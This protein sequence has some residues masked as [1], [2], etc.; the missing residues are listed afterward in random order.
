MTMP[1]QNL[2][3]YFGLDYLVLETS[4]K[5]TFTVVDGPLWMPSFLK[6]CL[7]GVVLR[8]RRGSEI[9]NWSHEF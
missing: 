4:M 3:R 9:D 5:V 8:L 6:S 7:A 1:F 2:F